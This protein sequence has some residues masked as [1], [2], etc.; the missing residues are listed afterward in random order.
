MKKLFEPDLHPDEEQ[1]Q[2]KCDQVRCNNGNGSNPD[3]IDR[4]EAYPGCKKEKHE[5]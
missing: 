4:P 1:D 3:A 5:K 2:H